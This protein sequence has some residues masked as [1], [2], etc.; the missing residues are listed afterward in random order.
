M[1]GLVW[2]EG[3]RKNEKDLEFIVGSNNGGSLR[4]REV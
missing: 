4:E 1:K 3:K 2:V